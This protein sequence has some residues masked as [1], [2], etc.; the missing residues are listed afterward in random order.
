MN[1]LGKWKIKQKARNNL[2]LVKTLLINI[3]WDYQKVLQIYLVIQEK[4]AMK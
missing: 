2:N 4:K 3:F 1:I